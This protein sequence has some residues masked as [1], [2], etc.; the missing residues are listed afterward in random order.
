[1]SSVTPGQRVAHQAA[2]NYILQGLSRDEAEQ[3]GKQDGTK[4]IKGAGPK[5]GTEIQ[6]LP[7]D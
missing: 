1:M 7:R 4:E 6:S 5:L 2:L 3:R